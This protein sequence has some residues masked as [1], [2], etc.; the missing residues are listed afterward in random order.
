MITS[1]H[2][3]CHRSKSELR[4]AEPILSK[5]GTKNQVEQMVICF[6]RGTPIQK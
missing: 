1:H 4:E 2:E 5:D 3:N 6:P